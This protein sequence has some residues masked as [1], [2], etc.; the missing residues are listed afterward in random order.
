MSLGTCDDNKIRV[1][2]LT[3]DYQARTGSAIITTER[4]LGDNED[5]PF[6]LTREEANAL[7]QFGKLCEAQTSKKHQHL[8]SLTKQMRAAQKEENSA[9]V[10]VLGERIDAL[11]DQL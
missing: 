7:E 4:V 10:Q 2:R 6:I 8:L 9:L 11:L 1:G 5:L 3:L